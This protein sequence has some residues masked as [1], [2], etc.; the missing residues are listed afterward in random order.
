MSYQWFDFQ[1]EKI[2][3]NNYFLIQPQ[4]AYDRMSFQSLVAKLLQSFDETLL[5][6]YDLCAPGRVILECFY[7]SV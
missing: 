5:L 4:V 3:V 1:L 6:F 7:F 2:K